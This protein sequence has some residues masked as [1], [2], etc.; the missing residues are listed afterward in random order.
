MEARADPLEKIL[1]YLDTSSVRALSGK[2]G[3]LIVGQLFTSILTIFELLDECCKSEIEYGM[4]KASL[5]KIINAKIAIALEMP[6]VKVAKSFTE[7][8][9]N[10]NIRNKEAETIMRLAHR[11]LITSSMEEFK[12]QIDNDMEWN[13][14]RN[15]YDD[16]V[17]RSIN[18]ALTT[19]LILREKFVSLSNDDLTSLRIN[20]ILS[21]NNRFREFIYGDINRALSIYTL[22]LMYSEELGRA[23][24]VEFQRKIYDSYNGSA[25][26]YI[27]ALSISLLERMEKGE[28]PAINDTFD[29]DHFAYLAPNTVLITNDKRMRALATKVGV[30]SAI[31]VEN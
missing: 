9:A 27:G 25:E 1:K 16:V 22:V 19:G 6:F 2:S 11:M 28:E 23:N 20:S 21:P 30:E 10:Y 14:I 15:A 18:R 4:R 8:A 17:R 31:G 3:R 13:R 7:I 12:P 5:K 29:L 26:P 24:D